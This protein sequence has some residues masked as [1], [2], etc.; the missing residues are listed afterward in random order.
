[1]VMQVNH[2]YS[3]FSYKGYKTDRGHYYL[4][5]GPPN[6]IEYHQS[7][8]NSFSYEIWSYYD[9]PP[10]G[11][12][13]VYFVFY[14]KDL[15]SRDYRLLHSNAVGELQN[16][17]WKQILAVDIDMPDDNLMK[18]DNFINRDSHHSVDE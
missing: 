9:F 16:L 3:N 12:V 13:N 7:D 11:Q 5:Y 10:T 17:R 6:Y 2:N 18:K 4:K 14:E 8:I 15:V 1:M